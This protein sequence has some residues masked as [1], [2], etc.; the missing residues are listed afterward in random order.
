[1]TCS[2]SLD[3]GCAEVRHG[4]S[5]TT[6][7]LATGAGLAGSDLSA[8]CVA[9]CTSRRRSSHA[10]MHMVSHGSRHTR[11]LASPA[12]AVM[13]PRSLLPSSSTS[14]GVGEGGGCSARQHFSQ[15]CAHSAA[16]PSSLNG[17]TEQSTPCQPPPHAHL[18]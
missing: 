1:M 14:A 7:S 9:E 2:A 10:E 16:Q 12:A 4:L 18:P 15:V 3:P 17:G 11:A 13:A 6:V 5:S 8:A